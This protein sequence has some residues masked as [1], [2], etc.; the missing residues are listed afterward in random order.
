MEPQNDLAE[1]LAV[2]RQSVSKWETDSAVPE[3]DKLVSMSELF[4][5]MLDELIKGNL[6]DEPGKKSQTVFKKEPENRDDCRVFHWTVGVILLCFGALIMLLFLLLGGGLG[7]LP[8]YLTLPAVR[9]YLPECCW[10]VGLC[11]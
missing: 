6:S 1:T 2:S 4:D 10:Q 9:D 8:L 3:L 11:L 7:G 5:V